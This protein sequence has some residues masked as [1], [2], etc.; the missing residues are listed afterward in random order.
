MKLSMQ[1][2]ALYW[3]QSGLLSLIDSR[4]HGNDSTREIISHPLTGITIK[5]SEHYELQCDFCFF[6]GWIKYN[7]SANNNQ[8]FNNI[9][10]D[11]CKRV[12]MVIKRLIGEKE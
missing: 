9:L 12:E 3:E 10:A 4:L 8:V 6:I 2:S 7:Q 11:Q 5:E 1:S